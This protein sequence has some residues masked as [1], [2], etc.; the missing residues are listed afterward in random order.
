MFDT[1][2]V[3]PEPVVYIVLRTVMSLLTVAESFTKTFFVITALLAT[4]RAFAEP[5]T[6]RIEML[7]VA[8]VAA[9][10]TVRLPPMV[11]SLVTFKET[12]VFVR[13][14]SVHAVN[15]GPSVKLLAAVIRL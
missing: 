8:I 6:F 3:S 11:A 4:Y 14:S 5:V 13:R 2:I 12:P 15:V 7:P 10:L 1:F 9:V